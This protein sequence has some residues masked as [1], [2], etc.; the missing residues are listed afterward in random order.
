MKEKTTK[1]NK[2]GK[3]SSSKWKLQVGD[4]VLAKCQAL[5]DAVDCITKKFVRAYDGPWKVTRAINPTT[6]EVANE[7]VKITKV[8]NQKAIKPYL[9]P[10]EF[11]KK[12]VSVLTAKK[13][14][15]MVPC[16]CIIRG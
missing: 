5:S 16:S 11:K 6:Y 10:T 15:E 13:M 9:P 1:R 8:F 12:Y 2:R 3:K 7:Q 14:P 4:L